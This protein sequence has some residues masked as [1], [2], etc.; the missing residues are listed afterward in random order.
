M[1]TQAKATFDVTSWNETNYSEVEGAGKL[2]HADIVYT[3]KGDI[4]GEGKL[5]YL[6][7]YKADGTAEFSG[8]ERVTGKL[9]G[10]DGSFVLVHEGVFKG[11]VARGK[12]EVLPGSGTGELV[13]LS[14][15]GSY[16]AD[17]AKD[18]AVTFNYSSTSTS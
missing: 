17:G 11:G 14:G 16:D 10:R 1:N 12:I 18:Q 7:A 9:A 4:Q 8:Y 6:M 2:V 5:Q 15:E 13:G 3:Y